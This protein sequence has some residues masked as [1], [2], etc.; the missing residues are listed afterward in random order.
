MGAGFFTEACDRQGQ[1][2]EKGQIGAGW[3]REG[4]VLM[5][6]FRFWLFFLFGLFCLFYYFSVVSIAY[7]FCTASALASIIWTTVWLS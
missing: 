2:K 3:K 6:L 4:G 5:N 1:K 7:V